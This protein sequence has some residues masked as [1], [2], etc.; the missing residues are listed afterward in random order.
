MI[1]DPHI[2]YSILFPLSTFLFP[3][4]GN[5]QRLHPLRGGYQATVTVGL[6]LETLPLLYLHLFMAIQFL[7]PLNRSEISR[8]E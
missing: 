1:A 5:R 6:F 7:V 2:F 4:Y 3:L 8:A